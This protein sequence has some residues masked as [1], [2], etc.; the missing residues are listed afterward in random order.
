MH[1]AQLSKKSYWEQF[2]PSPEFVVLFLPGEIF[3]SSAL[4]QD[5]SLIELGVE[6]GVILAT[7]TTLIALLRAIAYG[8]NQEK[9][10]Q[11]AEAVCK[12]GQELY[13]R[14]LDMSGHWER[15]GKSLNQ[16][17]HAYNKAVGSLE[18]RVLVSARKF[19]DLGISTKKDSLPDLKG[20]ETIPR[21]LAAL[22]RE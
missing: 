1:I 18:S 8:W 5:P 20:V 19:Q 6:Q 9:V 11:N 4:E 16:T 22:N 14:L 17:L 13:K 2:H 10:S 12:L 7:P 21:D 3:F 15:M